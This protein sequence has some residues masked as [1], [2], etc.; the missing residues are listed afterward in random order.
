MY[1]ET[2]LVVGPEEP[3]GLSHVRPLDLS[4][5]YRTPDPAVA[6]GSL[7]QF[8]DG[9][10]VAANPVYARLGNPNVR[11][12]ED[13]MTALEAGCDSVAFASG[14]AAI[15]AL[16]LDASHQGGH[17]VAV[18]PVYGGTQRLLASGLFGIDVTWASPQDVGNAIRPDTAL[19]FVETPANPTLTV[20]DIAQL[21]SDS[22]G[23]PV[24]VDSTFATPVLQNPLKHGADYVVHSA[25]K[26]IGGRGDALGGV[27]TTRTAE[28]AARLRLIRIATGAILHP[29][30]AHAFCGGLQTLALRVRAQQ[31]N[32]QGLV[33]L[34]GQHPEVLEVGYPGSTPGSAGIVAR[35]MSGPGSLITMRLGG[36]AQRADAFLSQ[37]RLAVPAVSLGTIDTL[38]QRPLALTHRTF[39]EDLPYQETIPED[40]IRISVGAEHVDDLWAD[41]EGAIGASAKS[42]ALAS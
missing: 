4:T 1:L 31:M 26:F 9:E 2:Q 22:R 36:G 29:V 27:V 34:L 15:A 40:L 18:P 28:A 38:V 11:E 8:A 25:T 13:R 39:D 33:R 35:Q 17:L 19:V 21:A 30:G 24:A 42:R 7:D 10:A 32:A 3:S 12:F 14:M 23:V 37:L 41:F 6:A 5:T 20:T 16:V